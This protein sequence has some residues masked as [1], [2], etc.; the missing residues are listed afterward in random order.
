[1]PLVTYGATRRRHHR[2]RHPAPWGAR[3]DPHVHLFSM[4]WTPQSPTPCLVSH[5]LVGPRPPVAAG[6]R[7]RHGR[8][9]VSRSAHV[10]HRRPP[11][12]R[13][14]LPH[15][16]RALHPLHQPRVRPPSARRPGRR[17]HLEDLEHLLR[18]VSRRPGLD[19]PRLHRAGRR[20]DR[21]A[22]KGL[23]SAASS[24]G[25]R[26][27]PVEKPRRSPPPCSPSSSSGS[28]A[29]SPASRSARSRSTSSR[30]TP[31]AFP[32]HF[33][34]HRRRRHHPRLHG[35]GLL[36][37]PANFPARFHLAVAWARIQPWLFAPRHHVM[38][39]FGM[40]F[41]GSMGVSRRSWDIDVQGIYGPGRPPLAR[42]RRYR[43]HPRLRSACWHL[44]AALR[45]H[46]A[47]RPERSATRQTPSSDWG[48]PARP[49][50]QLK[51]GSLADD[52]YAT[53]G[54]IVLTIVFL[55]CF[56]VYY[57]ANWKAL[58]DVWSVR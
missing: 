31:S 55:A 22:R 26:R 40:S 48:T 42:R 5:D 6:Q 36:R 33:H 50:G 54:T 58:A 12:Q 21:H 14:R 37:H 34:V 4:G 17:R 24:A 1:M 56:A 43:R 16:L 23:R 28:S 38:V 30:T 11:G 47:L 7:L 8:R 57:F 35:S 46:V 20:R 51:E 52:H 25:S 32:G 39:S 27:L 49:R 53:K 15:R 13:G 18:H 19:D 10:I 2:R 45:R 29:A 3:D 9:L 44:R 41:A